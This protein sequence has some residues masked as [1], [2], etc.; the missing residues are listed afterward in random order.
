MLTVSRRNLLAS[1][2]ALVAL[3]GATACAEA[4]LAKKV[5]RRDRIPTGAVT[6]ITIINTS[7]ATVSAGSVTQLIGCPFKRG[8]IARGTWP[9]FQ[10]SDGTNVPC[11]I[12]HRLARNWKDGSL[13]FVSVLLS[14]PEPIAGNSSVTVNVLPNGTM[15]SPSPRKLKDF[16]SSVDPQIQVDGMDNLSGTWVMSLRQAIKS[17]TR[18]ECYGNGAAGAV[19]KVRAIAQQNAQNHGQLVCD[20][21]VASL[22]N[23]D[24]SL[25]GLRI[26][27][28]V[29]LPY[30]DTS[31]PMNWMSFS[32]FRLCLDS[33]GTLIRDCF[34]QNFGSARAYNF[35]WANGSTFN[36]NAGYSASDYAYCTRLTT[37]GTLPT[38]LS[39]N[40]SYFTGNPT[41]STIGFGTCA[42][43][44]AEFLVS[45]TDNG[46]GTHTATPYPYLSYFGALFTAGPSGTWD[47]VQGAGT[48][49]ADTPLRF[50][51]NRSYWVSTQLIPSYDLTVQA[52]SNNAAY[53]WPNCSG[54]VT[55]GLSTTG[56]RD[57]LGILPSWYV[58]HFLTQAPV[59][60]QVVRVVSL[61]GGHGFSIGLE[62]STT[63]SFPCANNGSDGNGSPYKGMPT[64]NP[65]FSWYAEGLANSTS[66]FTDT[67]NPMVQLAGFS[68]Q[69]TTHMPQFN[70]YPYLFTGEP[71]HLDTLLEHANNAV[72]GRW[73]VFGSANITNTYYA[74]GGSNGGG[75][76][77]LQVYSNPARYGITIGCNADQARNDAWASALVA[78]AAAICPG[79]PMEGDT[80]KKY[81]ND[82]NTSTW[83]AAIDIFHALPKFA[84]R[85]GL[86]DIDYQ[87]A[88]FTEGWELAYLG[89][90]VSLAATATEESRALATLKAH[91]RFFDQIVSRFS[92]WAIGAYQT[93]VKLGSQMGAPLV[94]D[95]AHIA[96]YGPVISWVSGGQFTLAPFSNYVPAN[97]DV[98]IFDD[99]SAT[100]AGFVNFKPYYFVNLNGNSFDLA[101]WQHG[102]AKVLTDSYSGGNNFFFVASK[103]PTTGSIQGYV[104]SPTCYTTEITGMLNYAVATGASVSQTTLADLNYRNQQAGLNFTSD[105]KWAM[106]TTFFQT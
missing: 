5:A 20:F 84:A 83:S 26:L 12:L 71:W 17:K 75:D 40:T 73:P 68:Q 98:I 7:S 91:T 57:D 90:A 37:T 44:P 76:R 78:S 56:E 16:Y 18:K 4:L 86:W 46:S 9:Q 92:G 13:K 39:P 35:S 30:Y 82:I 69:D 63:L 50:Q 81:F 41:T 72:Y 106:T 42:T 29:K 49:V 31:A 3:T 77:A 62:N 95:D 28:K 103:P 10:L 24:G 87:K 25:K 85:Y 99:P 64:P 22:A 47:F 89:A 54:P 32:R 23:P 48:D 97:G 15:P 19:W 51:A 52:T 53:Y 27:G 66:G 33:Q 79:R 43:V 14:I 61:I 67:T 6:T 100:P 102:A 60:E 65:N 93:I 38:G 101:A 105:P 55:R 36:A 45:A 104:G 2:T 70:Y 59:D 11:T 21:Y 96:F 94:T 88:Y 58:R 8:D 74:L 80:Y 34:G 1:A